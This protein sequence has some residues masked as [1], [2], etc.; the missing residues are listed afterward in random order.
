ML[1]VC[2][3]ALI[4]STFKGSSYFCFD[5]L[6]ELGDELDIDIRFEQGRAYFFQKRIKNLRNP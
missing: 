5:L 6:T 2:F 4:P 1:S 3:L